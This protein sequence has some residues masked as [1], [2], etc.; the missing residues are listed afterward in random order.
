M[1]KATLKQ[2]QMK[3]RCEHQRERVQYFHK[4]SIDYN[5]CIATY[6]YRRMRNKNKR[7]KKQK[8]NNNLKHTHMSPNLQIHDQF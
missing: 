6:I 7:R 1:N 8:E 2:P 4:A 3:K 5:Q